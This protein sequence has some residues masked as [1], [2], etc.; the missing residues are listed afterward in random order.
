MSTL[1]ILCAITSSV[2]LCKIELQF[3]PFY[4]DG[5]SG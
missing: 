5:K 4:W 2:F 1:Q 3:L